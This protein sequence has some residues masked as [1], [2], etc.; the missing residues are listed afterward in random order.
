M[1]A[2]LALLI[3]LATAVPA[4]AQISTATVQGKVADQTGVLPA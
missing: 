3:V 4:A 1:R 2:A